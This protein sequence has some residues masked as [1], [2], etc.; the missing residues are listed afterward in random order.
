MKSR[1]PTAVG[2]QLHFINGKIDFLA[3]GTIIRCLSS[4]ST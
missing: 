1:K 4:K 3:K 2:E